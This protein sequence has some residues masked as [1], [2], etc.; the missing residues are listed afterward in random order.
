MTYIDSL[1][2]ISAGSNVFLG[3]G[4]YNDLK[5]EIY[6]IRSSLISYAID[7]TTNPNTYYYDLKRDC[8]I[9]S[10]GRFNTIN[11]TT[12]TGCYMAVTCQYINCNAGGCAVPRAIKTVQFN[13]NFVPDNIFVY[14]RKKGSG[15]A[16]YQVFDGL[17]GSSY[18]GCILLNNSVNLNTLT[19]CLCINIYQNN[20]GISCISGW[21]YHIY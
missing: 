2:I 19:G 12:T 14:A 16:C 1:Q 21:G 11:T 4:Y 8:F 17:T 15:S 5:N 6:N 9:D 7:D 18:T 10:N 13:N 20:D 3:C